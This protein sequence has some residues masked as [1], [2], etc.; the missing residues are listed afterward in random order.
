MNKPFFS[1]GSRRRALLYYTEI[2]WAIT[3]TSDAL[4]RIELNRCLGNG[5]RPTENSDFLLNFAGTNATLDC[6]RGN[7][8]TK[9]GA[10]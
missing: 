2:K 10:L 8:Y 3:P 1:I 4:D 7:T 5:L 9:D 6:D